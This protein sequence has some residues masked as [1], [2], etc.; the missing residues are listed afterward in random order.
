[1]LTEGFVGGIVDVWVLTGVSEGLGLETM[2][3][4]KMTYD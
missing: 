3:F 1:M 2:Y 4:D